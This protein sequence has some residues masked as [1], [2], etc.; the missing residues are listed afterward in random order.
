MRHFF[1]VFALCLTACG[2]ATDD[3]GLG[4]AT[5]GS[6]T[7]NPAV[8][9]PI[10]GTTPAAGTF[11]SVTDTGLT[12]NSYVYSDGTKTL[13]STAAPTNGQIM[14]GSTGAAPVLASLTAG[15]N[16]TITPGAGTITIAAT[17]GGTPGFNTIT[18]GTN[19]TAAMV[20]GTGSTLATS[21]SGAITATAVPF[22]GV[23]S[24]TNTTGA[25]VLGTGSSLTVS[26]SGT[27]NATTLNGATFAAPGAIGGTTPGSV[28]ATT[29]SASGAITSTLATGTAPF[30][31]ASTTQV[32][33]L[34][35]S[36]LI[37]ATWVSPGT[38]GST[39][40]STGAFT[41]LSAGT[42]KF[43]IDANG[44]VTKI[45][46]V[47]TSF[48]A[49]QGGA[50]T[51]LQN[52]GAGNLSW[53]TGSGTTAFSGITAGTNT[54]ALVMGTGGSLD[55]SGSGT[56]NATTLNGKTFASPAAIGTGTPAGAS[57]TT[58]SASGAL[59][60]TVNGAL[61]APGVTATGTW[62]TG[63]SATTTKPY[64]LFE[65]T[66]TTS[67]AW[68]TNGTGVGINAASG[69]TG[70]LIDAQLAGSSVFKVNSAGA[71]TATSFSGSAGSV[72]WNTITDPASTQLL[73]M[74]ANTTTWQWNTA[75]SGNQF[76]I[77]TSSLTSGTL[78]KFSSSST[79]SASNTQ[80]VLSV[81]TL[82]ANGTSSQTTYGAQFSNTHGGS[83]STNIAAA[84]TSSGATT[85]ISAQ[86][87]AGLVD[88]QTNGS[89]TESAGGERLTGTWATGGSATTTKPQFLIEPTGTTTTG[90]NTSGTGLGV[91]AAGTTGLIADFQVT[92]TSKFSIA[93]TGFT[94]G[95]TG[96]IFAGTVATSTNSTT[97]NSVDGQIALDISNINATVN[98]WVG[99]TFSGNTTGTIGTKSAGIWS[100]FTNRTAGQ[101]ANNLCFLTA[102]A[103]AATER[104]RMPE[105]GGLLI[106]T[107]GN[108]NAGITTVTGSNPSLLMQGDQSANIGSANV[109]TGANATAASQFLFKTRTTTGAATTIIT[110]GDGI[111]TWSGYGA[112]G[113][114][115]RAMGTINIVSDG[116]PSSGVMPAHFDFL[117]N[118]GGTGTTQAMRLTPTRNLLIGTTT[119]VTGNGGLSVNGNTTI[120]GVA[121]LAGGSNTA[122]AYSFTGDS[123]TGVWSSAADTVDIATGGTNQFRISTSLITCVLPVSISDTTASTSTSTGSFVTSGGIGAAGS[124]YA[125][126]DV[127][128][129]TIGKSLKIAVGTNGRLGNA[130]LVG[131]SVTVN[132]PSISSSTSYILLTRK[133]S[134]GTIGTGITYTISNATSFT[135]TSDNVLDTS[136]FTYLVVDGA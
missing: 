124:I 34:N 70:N 114:V 47:T 88:V 54:A 11:T 73:A 66:G 65:P 125:G 7:F 75:T 94:V 42:A 52:D 18:S 22:S 113:V 32:S 16:V 128:L 110:N 23:S 111:A 84:F 67:A 118:S 12:A 83:T 25:L 106:G 97:L 2:W 62:I 99:V 95:T 98:N 50:S 38:I 60:D 103:S 29:I 28:A 33:N 46:N 91:N 79:A 43:A 24:S 78:V 123:N 59:T 101:F 136:T 55:V 64:V 4:P 58:L 40:P 20:V 30:T 116:A 126:G 108:A 49:S 121:F 36:Q 45:N 112:D 35:A 19:S 115:Y 107:A 10:G 9:G 129:S 53:A 69:F 17:S 1:L 57:F 85:N 117:V 90:W 5:G 81:A 130:T 109:S 68:S 135:I 61:S 120:G 105:A 8:P 31:V 100:Q 72:V 3:T 13:A 82:G 102:T 39:T 76:A 56:I 48:P 63:G 26:G 127:A 14:I 27:N 104:A 133:T 119:D 21:G 132:V 15:S 122:P 71:V 131:G 44:N 77:S 74:G 87:Q 51:F 80:T 41:T 96:N 93:N 89:T 37:G 86:F 92:G 6:G 134:G